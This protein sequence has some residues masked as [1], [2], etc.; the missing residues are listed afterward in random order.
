MGSMVPVQTPDSHVLSAYVTRPAGT[1]RGGMLV[2]SE[3]F[4]VTPHIREV[5]DSYAQDGYL[6][7]CP[8]FYDRYRRDSVFT[9]DQTGLEGARELLKVLDFDKVMVDCR[10]A[11]AWLQAES[12]ARI[13]M[14]GY[15]SGGTS[16]WL[17]SEKVAG[18]ACSV[19]YYGSLI[20]GRLEIRPAVPVM[21][22]W[23]A[24]DHTLPIEEVHAFERA[25]PEVQ[26]FIYDT[27]H[28][29]NCDRR[30][31]HFHAQSAA[32]ARERTLAFFRHNVG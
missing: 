5:A 11:V 24:S 6:V 16:A 17:A 32:L 30:A 10:G 12:V 1:P 14:T 26:S 15:C 22:H 31:H 9:Y 18:L 20:P 4:G 7:I 23:G 13:G 29:F 8:Q 28:G 27:G 21:T 19:A 2:A 25:H 3:L